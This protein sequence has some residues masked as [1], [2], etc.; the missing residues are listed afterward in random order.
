MGWWWIF[1]GTLS[2]LEA[3]LNDMRTRGARKE[4]LTGCNLGLEMTLG[5]ERFD[6]FL[7]LHLFE[8][9]F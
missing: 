4:S 1:V 7:S 6:S 8:Y 2:R 9:V 3:R 5:M